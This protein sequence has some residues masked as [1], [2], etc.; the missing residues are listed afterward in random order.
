M[1]LY[2]YITLVLFT[3]FTVCFIVAKHITFSNQYMKWIIQCVAVAVAADVVF[4][5]N[6]SVL[7]M[8][9]NILHF[10]IGH[11]I[12]RLLQLQIA[13]YLTDKVKCLVFFTFSF[14]NHVIACFWLSLLYILFRLPQSNNMHLIEYFDRFGSHNQYINRSW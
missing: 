1:E 8:H 12:L 11:L 14:V 10:G 7:C 5:F 13:F 9:S 3:L 6:S 2:A 4:A